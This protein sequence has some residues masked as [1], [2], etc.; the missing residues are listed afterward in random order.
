MGSGPPP[1]PAWWTGFCFCFR[2]L[3]GGLNR[4]GL[5]KH[6]DGYP[7]SR[8]GALRCAAGEGPRGFGYAGDVAW[9]WDLG[10]LVFFSRPPIPVSG[11]AEQCSMPWS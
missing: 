5:P 9:M 11:W 4:A 3:W 7:D 8:G 1:L 10:S 6:R 2:P